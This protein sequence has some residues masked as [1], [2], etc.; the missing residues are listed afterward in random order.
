MDAFSSQRPR[1]VDEAPARARHRQRDVGEARDVGAVDRREGR[2][3]LPVLRRQRHPERPA[4]RRHRRRRARTPGRAVQGL[5]RQAA[6]STGSTTARSRSTS[7]SSRIATA[8]TTSSTA[9]GGTATS[10]R[11]NDDFTGFVPFP[12]G[13]HLQGDH[14]R[15]ATSKARSCSLKDGKYY[16]MWSEG[17]W[18]G[19]NY[20]VAYAVGLVAVRAVR[21]RRQDSAAGLDG[22]DRRG[23]PLG[24]A[25]A[26]IGQVVHRLPPPAARRDRPQSSR[27]EHRRAALRRA[28]IIQPVKITKEGV[29]ADPLPALAAAS[30]VQRKLA[31]SSM[32]PRPDSGLPRRPDTGRAAACG[33]TSPPDQCAATMRAGARPLWTHCSSAPMASNDPVRHR[34]SSGSRP[35]PCTTRSRSRAALRSSSSGPR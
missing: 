17:G 22:R 2:L 31:A 3:V 35:A 5:P 16:F 25:L 21:A 20:A 32:L 13:T 29:A 26:G 14:A 12:D 10:R 19:P 34:R 11:L 33:T 9:A 24:A 18:T 15:R 6:R 28:R 1:H 4:A 8:R 30:A 7:S 23:P 27:R